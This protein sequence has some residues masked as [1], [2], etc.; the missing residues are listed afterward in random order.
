METLGSR[1]LVFDLEGQI[2]LQPFLERLNLNSA[3]PESTSV[4]DFSLDPLVDFFVCGY[5]FFHHKN[6]RELI[7]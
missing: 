1:V 6:G 2:V 3:N 7:V 5:A 4:G